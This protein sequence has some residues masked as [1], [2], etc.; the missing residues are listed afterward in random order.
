MFA[1][2]TCLVFASAFAA[3]SPYW[4]PPG[5]H[6][7]RGV[8]ILARVPTTQTKPQSR[9]PSVQQYAFSYSG[10]FTVAGIVAGTISGDT[11]TVTSLISY[12]KNGVELLPNPSVFFSS[13]ATPG[14]GAATFSVSGLTS[15]TS[16][17]TCDS[18]GCNSGFGINFVY[19]PL[20]AADSG[21][22]SCLLPTIIPCGIWS[23]SGGI[24]TPGCG[25]CTPSI[26]VAGV[27][28]LIP[29]E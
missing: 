5:Y 6:G 13:G 10:T 23:W 9:G 3:T 2:V 12:V 11:F 15:G 1:L 29:T 7:A 8:P 28:L 27:G 24:C 19:N 25:T 18:A 4:P 21:N 17:F 26:C 14:S 20:H 16:L 22:F